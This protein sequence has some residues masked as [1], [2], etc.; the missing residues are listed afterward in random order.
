MSKEEDNEE[1]EDRKGMFGEK[2][3][4]IERGSE[5]ERARKERRMK[6][7]LGWREEGWKEEKGRDFETDKQTDKTKGG[8]ER[9]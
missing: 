1:E 9:R 3:G 7:S 4:W 2:E 6:G 8:R 5:R